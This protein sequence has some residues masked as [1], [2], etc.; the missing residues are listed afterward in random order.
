M[1]EPQVTLLA[2]LVTDWCESCCHSSE[3]I[4]ALAWEFPPVPT[5]GFL[6]R[7]D[8]Q[9]LREPVSWSFC[10]FIPMNTALL[11]LLRLSHSLMLGE[12]QKDHVIQRKLQDSGTEL[13]RFRSAS[14][15][16]LT[17]ETS[18]QPKLQGLIGDKLLKMNTGRDPV[19]YITE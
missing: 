5:T 11:T 8:A 10:L 16:F 1:W 19:K 14:L 15:I 7:A 17:A 6:R 2:G 18:L 13:L 9:S 12:K 4:Q 3:L